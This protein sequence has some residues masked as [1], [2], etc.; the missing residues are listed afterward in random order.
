[1]KK[2][3]RSFSCYIDEVLSDFGLQFWMLMLISQLFEEPLVIDVFCNKV[4]IVT[5]NTFPHIYPNNI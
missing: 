4:G 1:M 3:A 2:L 5:L